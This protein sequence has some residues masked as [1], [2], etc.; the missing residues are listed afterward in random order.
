[1]SQRGLFHYSLYFVVVVLVTQIV[2]P[3]P[4]SALAQ[5][6]RPTCQR[7]I[8]PPQARRHEIDRE[9]DLDG[10]ASTRPQ[11]AQNIAKNNFCATNDGQGPLPIT[12]AHMVGLQQVTERKLDA[13]NIPWGGGNRLPPDRSVLQN[14]IRSRTR[15]S[16]TL[17]E[18]TL[19]SLV[20]FVID[21]RHSNVSKGESVNC[22]RGG[23]ENNDIHIELGT[24]LDVDPCQT[25][26][27][28]ISPHFRPD[29]WDQFDNYEIYHPVR[30]TGQLFFDASHKP[31]SAGRRAR[32]ARA[33]SWEIHPVYGID[34]CTSPSVSHCT[35][36][37]GTHWI[38]FS[39]WKEQVD[40]EEA[41]N[42]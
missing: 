26:T 35:S 14:L 9:C 3:P 37:N 1:M 21:A 39:V 30:I 24:R 15:P 20:A 42:E 25:V 19:V 32:P 7:P 33:S 18:G 34:V 2:P 12:V 13:L 40:R 5:E 28:E 16:L 8:L 27:A 31:C 22:K 4:S 17:G 38:P 23:E 11:A 29:S 41:E 10:S 36:A 6:F